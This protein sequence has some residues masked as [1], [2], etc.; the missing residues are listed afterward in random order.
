[1]VRKWFLIEHLL[2]LF[3]NATATVKTHVATTWHSVLCSSVRSVAT[4][5]R[6][7]MTAEARDRQTNEDRLLN[8]TGICVKG[9]IALHSGILCGLPECFL[10][11]ER[12]MDE[13]KGFW[14]CQIDATFFYDFQMGT[15]KFV[16]LRIPC[17]LKCQFNTDL[18]TNNMILL[19]WAI[20]DNFYRQIYFKDGLLEP[21]IGMQISSRR[22]TDL[23]IPFI[24]IWIRRNF[25]KKTFFLYVI[26]YILFLALL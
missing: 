23:K 2:R 1:M 8:P 7:F 5:M 19:F 16:R 11:L 17:F 6:I 20:S 14:S 15:V 4:G 9:V 25:H 12:S 26:T 13:N 3:S 24:S 22:M 10:S 21:S 18:T